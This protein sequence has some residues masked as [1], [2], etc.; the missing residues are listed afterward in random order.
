MLFCY[1]YKYSNF[2]TVK[3]T[4]EQAECQKE[5]RQQNFQE[6]FQKCSSL[7]QQEVLLENFL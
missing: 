3:D 1:Y 5:I 2:V 6:A 7:A 4:Y